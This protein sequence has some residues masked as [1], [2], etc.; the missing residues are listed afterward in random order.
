VQLVASG[1]RDDENLGAGTFAKFRA[2]RI[3]LDVEFAHSVDA[4]QHAAGSSG[5]HVVFGGTGE[6]HAVEEELILLRAVAGD[7]EIVG[8]RGVRDTRAAGFLRS[9]IHD[10]GVQGEEQII[11]AA[12]QR[13]ILDL[14]L[15]DETRDVSR[16]DAHDG[17]VAQDC[18]FRAN[19]ADLQ[20]KINA[21]LLTDN[22]FYTGT[23]GVLKTG[24]GH[25]DFVLPDRQSE[26]LIPP[27][28]VSDGIPQR[29][30]LEILNRHAGGRN[31]RAGGVR[32]NARHAG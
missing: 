26:D 5:R 16:G 17:S 27:R 7:G 8:S 1:P 6:F 4:Q 18:D 2:V 24:P 28:V 13:K 23:G 20:A 31:W 19:G 32:N 29:S 14:L 21:G 11:A 30:S 3:A 15:G 22:E 10:A 25:V 9:E 12:V